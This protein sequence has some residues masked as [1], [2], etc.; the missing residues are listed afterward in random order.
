MTNSRKAELSGFLSDV[1]ISSASNAPVPQ[2]NVASGVTESPIQITKKASLSVARSDYQ[3]AL[4]SNSLFI[5]PKYKNKIDKIIER[6]NEPV[7]VK[8]SSGTIKT[9]RWELA[10]EIGEKANLPPE[11]VIGVWYRED[12]SMRADRYLHN[13][14]RLGKTTKLVPRGIFFRED[15]FVESSVSALT[16]SGRGR[17]L[18]LSYD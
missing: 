9:T 4:D 11:L 3:K 13:G 10:K 6:V 2:I 16:A 8:T 18:E 1:K 15:Q 17:S 12:S 7:N 14:E 5:D